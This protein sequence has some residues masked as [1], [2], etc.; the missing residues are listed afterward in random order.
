MNL[1]RCTQEKG[2]YVPPVA[3]WREHE[4]ELYHHKKDNNRYLPR[5]GD[6]KKRNKNKFNKDKAKNTNQNSNQNQN[7][8]SGDKKAS[9]S[10]GS[11]SSLSWKNIPG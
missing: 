6:D 8:A 1:I 5:K 3:Q 10:N 4:F 2:K 11:E 7:N 9:N